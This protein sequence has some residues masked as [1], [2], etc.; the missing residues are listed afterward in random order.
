MNGWIICDFTSFS[1]VFQLYQDDYWV[2]MKD[3]VQWNLVYSWE[4][5][6]LE[7]GSNPGRLDQLTSVLPTELPGSSG[8]AR[9]NV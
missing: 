8:E 5:S 9:I 1:T 2:I 4:D 7:R 3:C 6:R